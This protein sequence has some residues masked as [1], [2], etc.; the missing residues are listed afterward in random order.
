M[1]R[2]FSIFFVLL[3]SVTSTFAETT[4]TATKIIPSG[5]VYDKATNDPLVGVNIIIVQDRQGTKYAQLATTGATTNLN[6]KF[7]FD[8]H[9]QVPSN[10]FVLA[11]YV[12]YKDTI[13]PVA[14]NMTIFLEEGLTLEEHVVWNK[15]IVFES[16][17][18]NT[19]TDADTNRHGSKIVSGATL[20]LLDSNDNVIET[21]TSD[22]E[23]RFKFESTVTTGSKIKITHN[24]YE[25]QIHIVG[26]YV[27]TISIYIDK[28]TLSGVVLDADTKKP[29]TGAKLSLKNA[30][31]TI[32]IGNDGKFKTTTRFTDGET[33]T[34]TYEGYKTKTMPINMGDS[35]TIELKDISLYGIVLNES[36]QKPIKQAKLQLLDSNDDEIAT[37]T[38]D[39]S[40]Y[41]RFTNSIPDGAK[42]KATRKNY[43]EKTVLVSDMTTL[44]TDRPRKQILLTKTQSAPQE[45]NDEDDE[46][47]KIIQGITDA[48]TKLND[49]IG[50]LKLSVWK[51][52]EGKFNTA[53]LASDS[54]AAVV[55]G[56]SGGLITSLV[57]R[58]KQVENGFEDIKCVIGGQNVAN[59][60]EEFNVNI[61]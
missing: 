27:E 59:W 51:N 42:I 55:L 45:E 5:T 11:S 15:G 9:K 14:E 61:Q 22:D 60:D 19:T 43:D 47:Q 28:I 35:I 37:K 7:R 49:I 58:K 53:R 50:K 2:I 40:G 39:I 48:D 54:V 44:T 8:N 52:E 46:L 4:D 23:G 30:D 38:S 20:Q 12:G 1:L 16:G 29:I 3:L 10:L 6:G 26:N 32:P 17:T 18:K 31:T 21:V 57:M 24:G 56:T 36:T 34:A 41:F 25:D 33:I 13:Q